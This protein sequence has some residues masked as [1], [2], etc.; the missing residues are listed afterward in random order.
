M[1]RNDSAESS[2][3][4]DIESLNREH[5]LDIDATTCVSLWDGTA[6]DQ[7]MA[8]DLLLQRDNALHLDPETGGYPAHFPPA[9]QDE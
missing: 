2:R 6:M 8:V 3:D 9:R 5:D 4:T 1:P 7:A